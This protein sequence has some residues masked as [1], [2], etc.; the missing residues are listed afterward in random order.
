MAAKVVELKKHNLEN[1]NKIKE[2][3]KDRK[4]LGTVQATGT[5]KSYL[6]AKFIQDM[7]G[8]KTLFLTSSLHIINEFCNNLV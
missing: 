1:Y 5:G 3:F 4:H 7:D 2:K 8:E 6:V